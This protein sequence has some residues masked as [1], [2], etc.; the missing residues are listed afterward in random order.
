MPLI[1]MS[2]EL[3]CF[4]EDGPSL[5]S[6]YSVCCFFWCVTVMIEVRFWALSRSDSESFACAREFELKRGDGSKV[7]SRAWSSSWLLEVVG[8]GILVTFAYA[9]C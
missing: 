8:C 9:V 1:S 4:A 3:S 2:S 7:R 6:K 5:V